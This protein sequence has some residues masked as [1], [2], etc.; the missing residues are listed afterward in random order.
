M[1]WF[2][3]SLVL[4]LV[5]HADR[6][7]TARTASDVGVV[8]L[9]LT[10]LAV[11]YGKSKSL[12]KTGLAAGS[13]ALNGATTFLAKQLVDSPRPD[14]SSNDGWP[15]GHTSTAFTSAGLICLQTDPLACGLS[16][17]A[18]AGVGVLRI[19][20]N[21]HTPEQVAWGVGWGL[22]HGVLFPALTASF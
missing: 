10:A 12:G 11:T 7:A 9:P 19:E 5:A 1:K 20:G 22:A 4:P 6:A 17:A 14:G 15:S 16:V 3:L 18:A 13:I 2:L 21:R 8:A